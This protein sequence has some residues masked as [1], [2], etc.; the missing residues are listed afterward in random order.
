MEHT[1]ASHGSPPRE[2]FPVIGQAEKWAGKKILEPFFCLLI[3]LPSPEDAL[4]SAG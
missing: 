2:L 4:G 1:P 3:F